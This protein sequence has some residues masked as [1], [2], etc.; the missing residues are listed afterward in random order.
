MEEVRSELKKQEQEID[1]IRWATLINHID[2]SRRAIPEAIR[3]AYCIVV[4][5]SEKN[6]VQAIKI[7]PSDDPLFQ[8]IKSDPRFPYPGNR[9]YCRGSITRRAL[10]ALERRRTFPS[11][12]D[13]VGA[14]AQFPHLPKMLKST[15]Y[16]GYVDRWVYSRH[17]YSAA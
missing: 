5:V 11:G 10:C 16:S 15:S 17:V 1:P 13:L 2:E 8:T 12:E 7:T 14:F 3:Q 9:G 4:T 6:E